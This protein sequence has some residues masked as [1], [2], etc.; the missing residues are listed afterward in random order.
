MGEAMPDPY[1]MFLSSPVVSEGTVYVGSGDTYVYAL[2][3]ATGALKWKFKTGDVV[4]ASPALE[5]GTLY[6]GGWDIWFYALDAA[7]GR[8][9]WRFH[10]GVDP[11]IHNQVGISSSA[12]LV[13][14]T[15]YFGCRDGHLYA[16]E[17]GTGALRWAFNTDHAWVT[18]S[19]VVHGNVVYL[20]AGSSHRFF[21]AD[22]NTGR[23]MLSLEF[24]RAFFSSA[25]VVGGRLYVGNMD[26]TL[27][28]LDLMS[29]RIA[30][31]FQTAASSPDASAQT[32]A[33]P[34][35][36]VLI[37]G[38]HGDLSIWPYTGNDFSGTPQ[39]P[40]N[41]V[42]VGRADPREIRSALLSLDGDRTAAGLPNLAPFNCTWSDAIGDL[43]TGYSDGAGWVGSAVQL[44]CG[45]FGPVR[46]H[47][48]LFQ[49]SNGT[50][51]NAHFELLIPGTTDHQ[52]L[53]WEL[54]EQLV[55][56]DLARTGLLGAAPAP[57]GSINAAPTFREIPAVIYNLMPVELRA[58]IGGPLGS[59]SGPVGIANDGRAT[60]FQLTGA[61]ATAPGTSQRLVIEYNQV[62]P[63]PFCS[64]G[65][66]D[67][68]LVQGPVELWKNV[69]IAG[70]GALVSEYHASG[71]LQLTPINPLTG[72][73]SGGSYQAEVSDQQV[74][75]YDDG[76]GMV[77]GILMQ[78][79]L[80]QN[81]S[82]R[83][84]KVVRLKVGPDGMTRYD[85]EIACQR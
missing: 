13:G 60:R 73:P 42:F 79:E 39:D 63:R 50:V 66:A 25:S 78:R 82:G 16:L 47:V 77:D 8:V 20:G 3:A 12:A 32:A 61:A 40:I 52:V 74:A 54:A 43:Q 34:G 14:G 65:P 72:A 64:T 24:D 69:Q 23:E 45:G 49:T 84:R 81:V 11:E 28:G 46:F 57:I 7:T 21:G 9:K 17:A 35:P 56:L 1:D 37:S 59:V 67:Y 75:R 27:L 31:R 85:A 26:G 53:S 83:G 38:D 62:V 18:S 71:R 76:G 22:I 33:A 36:L 6:I 29:G 48:R 2:D 58:A 10:T 15:V 19:P 5:G 4:H 70:A 44:A 68:L 30:S 41:L 55:T 80:P 51:G